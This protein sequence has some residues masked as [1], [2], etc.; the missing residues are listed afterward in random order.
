MDTV[1]GKSAV[2]LEELRR[3]ETELHQ[4]ETRCNRR[5]MERLLHPDFVEFGRSGTPYTRADV[6]NEFGP[7]NLLP[8]IHSR[9]FE[10]A[11]L[12]EGVALLT[13]VSAH[14]DGGGNQYRHT[15]RCSVW[16]YTEAGWQMRFHQGT[17][18]TEAVLERFALTD[19]L[20]PVTL[21]PGS[22][23]AAHPD[24]EPGTE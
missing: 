13:Y 6:L 19:P 17:P 21:V 2:L 9:N 5:R 24:M 1:G 16:V 12:A 8:E 14:V 10:L 20:Q 15:L 11:V 3:L 7:D 18:T 23:Q 22:V 4:Q